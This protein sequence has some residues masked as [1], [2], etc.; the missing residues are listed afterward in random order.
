MKYHPGWLAAGMLIFAV[1]ACNLSKNNNTSPSK[2]PS[3]TDVRIDRISMAKDDNGKPGDPTDSFAPDDR[4][5]HTVVVLNKAKEGTRIKWVWIA[6]NAEGFQRNQELKLDKPVELTTGPDDTNVHAHV[7][8]SKD[9]PTGEY[10]AE[11]YIN[12][13]L[14]KTVSYS[15]R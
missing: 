3:G 10:R 15:V 14:D 1:L 9:W 4:T 2:A 5:I 7:T 12:G 13:V 8:W 11:V 6:V